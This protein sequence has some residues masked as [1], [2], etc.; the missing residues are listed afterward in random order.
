VTYG[1]ADARGKLIGY[2]E[3]RDNTEARDRA[4]D[5]LDAHPDESHVKLWRGD[6]SGAAHV[7]VGRGFVNFDAE[8]LLTPVPEKPGDPD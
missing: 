7:V 5:W 8:G 4:L 6:G 1:M 2:L 3:A